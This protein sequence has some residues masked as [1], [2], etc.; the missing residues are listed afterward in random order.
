[1]FLHTGF[2]GNKTYY[3]TTHFPAITQCPGTFPLCCTSDFFAWAKVGPSYANN[4]TGLVDWIQLCTTFEGYNF[5][6]E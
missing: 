3:G 5:I 4:K 2:H 6:T 1:M